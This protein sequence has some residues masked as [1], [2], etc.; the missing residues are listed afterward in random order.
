M[1]SPSW[2]GRLPRGSTEGL[3]VQG[4][5]MSSR[6]SCVWGR[7][8]WPSLCLFVTGHD[9]IS[10]HG[11]SEV[12]CGGGLSPQPAKVH[13]GA[14][15][16]GR[17]P[18]GLFHVSVG[19]LC[20]RNPSRASLVESLV[21]QSP[22]NPSS[23]GIS[24]LPAPGGPGLQEAWVPWAWGLGLGR[25]LGTPGGLATTPIHLP[26]W[27]ESSWGQDAAV[28]LAGSPAQS[29]RPDLQQRRAHPCSHGR[30]H[31]SSRAGGLLTQ[32]MPLGA[33]CLL[34][35]AASARPPGGLQVPGAHSP[36]KEVPGE[37]G[38]PTEEKW[39][40][41]CLAVSVSTEGGS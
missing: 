2:R 3:E 26:G 13:E 30:H 1:V 22:A 34:P 39:L 23:H 17:E 15:H 38:G 35:P 8:L 10:A 33:P 24:L 31:S 36:T 4:S 11:H 7:P 6:A 40:E 27:V 19:W 18:P 41:G 29:A 28:C 9:F 32:E 37:M 5:W 16:T 20:S 14:T 21:E 25:R 12:A